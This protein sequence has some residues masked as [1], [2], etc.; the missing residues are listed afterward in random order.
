MG[1]SDWLVND[2]DWSKYQTTDEVW[3]KFVE[4]YKKTEFMDLFDE[5]TTIDITHTDNSLKVIHND[6]TNEWTTNF[7][8]E[9]CILT[10]VPSNDDESMMSEGLWVSNAILALSNLYDYD[11][12]KV[13]TF[14]EKNNKNTY[15]LEK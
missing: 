13:E 6:G 5:K 14:L 3:E 4:K 9:N 10:Y 12:E 2:V 1:D 7:K 8:Y 15:K 11:I